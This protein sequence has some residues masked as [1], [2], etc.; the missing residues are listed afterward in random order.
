M[1]LE[2]LRLERVHTVDARRIIPLNPWRQR[3]QLTLGVSLSRKDGSIH[4]G[5]PN[6][7]IYADE[8]LLDIRRG[9]IRFG[10]SRD[11]M[12]ILQGKGSILITINM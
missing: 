8:C 12:V 5:L 11:K 2:Y 1:C 9:N 4:V 6:M 3:S 7:K 10:G